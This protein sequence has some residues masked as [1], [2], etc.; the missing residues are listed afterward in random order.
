[1]SA[2]YQWLPPFRIY[3][4][5]NILY[6]SVGAQGP[7]MDLKSCSIIVGMSRSTCMR[8]KAA[9]RKEEM[10]QGTLR[11]SKWKRESEEKERE[12]ESG[13]RGSF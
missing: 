8:R 12:R 10:S 11:H 2:F 3:K 1:M 13:Y 4:Y 9:R 6:M 7:G 5:W